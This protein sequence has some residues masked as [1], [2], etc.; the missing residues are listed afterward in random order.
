MTKTRIAVMILISGLI[1]VGV[2]S[3]ASLGLS[4]RSL[5][6][7]TDTVAACD[8]DGVVTNYTITELKV[9]H[10]VVSGIADAGCSGAQLSVTL[11]GNGDTSVGSGGPVTVTD[12]DGDT[13]DN[14]V[15]VPISAQPDAEL[16]TGVSVLLVGP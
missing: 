3:A 7:G 15:I 12:P 8:Q 1:A 9:T 2:G 16:V 5:G 14:T 13:S 11:T 10:V 6:A 4:S